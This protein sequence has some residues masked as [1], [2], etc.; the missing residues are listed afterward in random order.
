MKHQASGVHWEKKYSL[1][2]HWILNFYLQ[3]AT[4]FGYDFANVNRM[5]LYFIMDAWQTD[6]QLDINITD[7]LMA[8]QRCFFFSSQKKKN[9]KNILLL[10]L[11]SWWMMTDKYQFGVLYYIDNMIL[12][13][14]WLTEDSQ[15]CEIHNDIWNMFIIQN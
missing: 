15:R 13:H 2:L 14:S 6:R 4:S 10:K 11:Q 12:K 3:E 7:W 9:G 1:K 8:R 5:T